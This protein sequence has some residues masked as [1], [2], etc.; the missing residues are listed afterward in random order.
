MVTV[1]MKVIRPRS[2]GVRDGSWLEGASVGIRTFLLP[3]RP[4]STSY[5]LTG[6][7]GRKDYDRQRM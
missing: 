7:V 3:S 2:Y 6:G 5:V 4:P 1:R